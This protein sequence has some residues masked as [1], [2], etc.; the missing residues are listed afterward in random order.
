MGG[1]RA[2]GLPGPLPAKQLRAGWAPPAPPQPPRVLAEAPQAGWVRAA[3]GRR[4]PAASD[5][6]ALGRVRSPA[7]PDT[8]QGLCAALVPVTAPRC[9]LPVTATQARLR[10]HRRARLTAHGSWVTALGSLAGTAPGSPV[11]MA[12]GSPVGMAHGS[13]LMAHGSWLQD[14]RWAQLRDHWWVRLTAHGSWLMAYSSGTTGGHG[15]GITGGHGP[16]P[17]AHSPRPT[18]HSSQPTAHGSAVGAAWWSPSHGTFHPLPKELLMPPLP[19]RP[20]RCP[21]AARTPAGTRW[22]QG[23]GW[24]SPA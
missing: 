10:D 22:A 8:A 3:G 2:P 1:L 6:R 13:Q 12:P 5:C 23:R 17:T 16:Q 9:T 21:P 7:V 4:V 24:G 19:A 15:S 11:G 20:A 14:H 18:A